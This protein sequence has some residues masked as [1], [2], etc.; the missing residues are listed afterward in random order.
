MYVTTR[1]YGKRRR[2]MGA[3]GVNTAGLIST[4]AAVATTTTISSLASGTALGSWAGPIG[5]GV[6]ALV[7]VIAGLW[8]AHDARAKG[9][10]DENTILNSAVQTFDSSLSAIFQAANSGQIAPADA[11]AA[12]SQLLQTFW[13]SMAQ[14]QTLPGT[15][16]ASGHG[17]NCGT[18]ISGQ[19]VPCSPQ[20]AP[21]CD[22]SCTASCCVGCNDFR[23]AVLD[24]IAVFGK[25]SG[26]TVNVCTVYGS[27][28]GLAQRSGY[29]LTYT[30]PAGSTVTA[31][32]GL[33]GLSG[34]TVAG[35]PAWMLLLGVGAAIWV[36]KS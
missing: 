11:Q 18:Y 29:S 17:A 9:A 15:A 16:D 6:G 26:G 23:P 30:P 8:A 4:G 13:S 14:Y 2:G 24:A 35:I 10:K 12:C 25:A 5:A 3:T 21:K 28:Y 19:T 22:K 36:A 20:G 1:A 27:K 7:G 32:L 31:A 33:S 34:G